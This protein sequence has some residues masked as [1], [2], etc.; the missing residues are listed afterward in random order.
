VVNTA[1]TKAA[2]E[3]HAPLPDPYEIASIRAVSAPSG[4]AGSNWHR[5]EITQGVNRIVG[6]RNGEP[7][8][9]RLALEAIVS[10]LNERR[11]HQR[12][13]VHVTLGH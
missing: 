7:D 6:Y 4:A 8:N 3:P 12:G 13:R 5:Y 2:E 1:A 10:R 11:H 9:V